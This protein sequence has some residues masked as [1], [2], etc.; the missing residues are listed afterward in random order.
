MTAPIGARIFSVL[1]RQTHDPPIRA[2]VSE[3]VKVLLVTLFNVEVE[4]D[5]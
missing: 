1:P 2:K 4:S 3:I 5:E